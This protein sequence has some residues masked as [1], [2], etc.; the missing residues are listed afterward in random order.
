M[1]RRINKIRWEIWSAK[2][3]KELE[4]SHCYAGGES[5]NESWNEWQECPGSGNS[6]SGAYVDF[7]IRCWRSGAS[8]CGGGSGSWKTALC[9]QNA[10]MRWA[11]ANKGSDFYEYTAIVIGRSMEDARSIALW[12]QNLICQYIWYPVTPY[13]QST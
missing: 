11:R 10:V 4:K 6:V 2:Q 13:V 3:N 7:Y 5:W 9:I 1:R 8:D 12:K